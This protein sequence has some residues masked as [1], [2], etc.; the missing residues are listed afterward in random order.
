MAERN[1]TIKT[2]ALAGGA[3]VAL[4]LLFG[5]GR[6]WGGV[7]QS[8]SPL[9]LGPVRLARLQRRDGFPGFGRGDQRRADLG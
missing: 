6:G 1:K 9:P 4:W 7:E 5:A 8:T 2:V 3:G